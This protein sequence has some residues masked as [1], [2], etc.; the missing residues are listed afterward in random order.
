MFQATSAY[1]TWKQAKDEN[2]TARTNA[3]NA[4][5]AAK[6]N[7]ALFTSG[8][9]DKAAYDVAVF[10][11]ANANKGTAVL[12]D[13]T[14]FYDVFVPY[15]YIRD[16]TT[17]KLAIA[18]TAPLTLDAKEVT[19]TATFDCRKDSF[20][21]NVKY[22]Y[23]NTRAYTWKLANG[24]AYTP[25]SESDAK[26]AFEAV[27]ENNA[28]RFAVKEGA[29]LTL[30][31]VPVYRV[32]TANIGKTPFVWKA[33]VPVPAKYTVKAPEQTPP[34]VKVPPNSAMLKKEAA[35]AAKA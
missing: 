33:F 14:C 28:Q 21:D 20:R 1:K 25:T 4:N 24:D 18:A 29:P 26:A 34:L 22:I 8:A 10:A 27:P 2:T 31:E 9:K 30:V 13:G 12:A 17:P 11:C 16:C 19:G 6:E 35:D 3:E 5:K 15:N 32:A 23:D 7:N